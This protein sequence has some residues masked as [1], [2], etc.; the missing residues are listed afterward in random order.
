[1]RILIIITLV[2]FYPYSTLQSDVWF[3]SAGN[4]NASKYSNLDQINK[5]N[6]NQLKKAWVYKSGFTP[7]KKGHQNN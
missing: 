1:M 5:E 6:I 3:T 2:F 7:I 4:Y